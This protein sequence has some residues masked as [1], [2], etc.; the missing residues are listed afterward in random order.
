MNS[1]IRLFFVFVEHEK[2][3]A[4]EIEGDDDHRKRESGGEGLSGVHAGRFQN[5]LHHEVARTDAGRREREQ[6]GDV[7]ESDR[8]NRYSGSVPGGV[9]AVR[10]KK[11]GDSKHRIDQNHAG[12]NADDD[13]LP[14][15]PVRVNRI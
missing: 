1:G 13:F 15:L 14:V 5:V 4:E 11:S 3:S 8:F 10:D 9:D 6:A 2:E 12:G 7:S